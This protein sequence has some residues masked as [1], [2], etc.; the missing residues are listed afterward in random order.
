MEKM[1]AV[2][3]YNP[4]SLHDKVKVVN[5]GGYPIEGAEGELVGATTFCQGMIYWIV[6]LRKA[7]YDVTLDHW[8]CFVSMPSVCLEKIDA[9]TD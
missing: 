2:D 9:Y 7:Q 4:L 1:K 6:S 3:L 5:V 8:T